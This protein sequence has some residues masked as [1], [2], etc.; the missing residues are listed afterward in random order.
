MTLCVLTRWSH[1]PCP[2]AGDNVALPETSEAATM[3]VEYAAAALGG[4]SIAWVV[5]SVEG[6]SQ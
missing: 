1:D 6:L 4:P 3:D 5:S 2:P